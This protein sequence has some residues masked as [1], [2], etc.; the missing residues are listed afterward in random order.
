V[1]TPEGRLF[2]DT[3]DWVLG[4]SWQNLD[5]DNSISSVGLY[6]DVGE[7][8]FCNPVCFTDRQIDSDFESD[9]YAVFGSIDSN[10]T[11]KLILS[12][13]LRYEY[14]EA[15]YKDTWTDINYPGPPNNQ[16][17]D[18]N[19]LDCKPDE[20][21]WGGHVALSYDWTADLRSYARIARGFKAGG[22]NP[23]LAALQGG[24]A[25]LGPE[26]IAYEDETL[27]NYE[28]GLKGA[29]LQGDLTADIAVFYMDREDAQLSQSSQQVSFDPNSFVFV[30]YNGDADVYGLEVSSAWQFA[31]DWQLHG[32]LGLLES[33]INSS[34]QTNAVSPGAVNRDL[35]HAPAYTLNLGMA[36]RNADGWYGRLDVT[37]VDEFY[38]DI[39]NN[40]KSDNYQI[41]N[42]R[43]GKDW[44]N[45]SVEAWGR[46]IFDE[47]YSTR[48]FYFENEP[49]FTQKNLY[50]KF[51]DPRAVGA[52]LRYRY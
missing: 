39:S 50:T 52:T 29:W 49:D 43:I 33:E 21:L 30:T 35:A 38:F 28:L 3:T 25:A 32:S 46:N 4:A 37:A 14:W 27:W 44:E 40:Q 23:S 11:D 26:Y 36:Y 13:G 8:N 1:S 20:N 12:V 15:D 24:G 42:L 45:W 22:F 10:L 47:D 19:E 2:N 48:G 41:V 5:E 18:V 31:R 34:S 51:G 17:C 9:T 6:S 16:T 7:E